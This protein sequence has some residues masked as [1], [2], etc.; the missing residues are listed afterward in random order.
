MHWWFLAES[1]HESCGRSGGKPEE[2]PWRPPL[3]AMVP[4]GG[5]GKVR[6]GT[7]EMGTANHN[8]GTTAPCSS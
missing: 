8:P 2:C 1:F 6:A 4:C 3:P 7:E 5:E